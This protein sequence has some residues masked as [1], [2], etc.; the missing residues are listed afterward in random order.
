M[1]HIHVWVSSNVVAFTGD[2]FVQLYSCRCMDTAWKPW[3][4][5]DA[6]LSS[7]RGS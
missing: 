3:T 5:R 7:S 6:W 1:T 4:A 2:D